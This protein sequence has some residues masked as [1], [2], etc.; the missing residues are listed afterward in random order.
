MYTGVGVAKQ[1]TTFFK[2]H[3][4]SEEKARESVYLVD[5]HGLIY[6]TREDGVMADHKRCKTAVDRD[7][8]LV[9]D[10]IRKDF[11]R[12]DYSGPP[13]KNLVDIIDLVKPT[14][15]MGLSTTKVNAFLF[16]STSW[17]SYHHHAG[18]LYQR[19]R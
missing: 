12:K 5:T 2:L 17:I 7:Y 10:V 9:I 19:N 18:C 4:L 3:G 8:S 11:S 1:L 6:D 14:A 15:L 13:I 16:S